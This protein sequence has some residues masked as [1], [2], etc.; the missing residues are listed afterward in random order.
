MNRQKDRGDRA[1]REI[2]ALLTELLGQPIRR[3]LGAGRLDDTGDLDGLTG[4]T[5]QVA[6]WS[7]ALRA[8][9]EKPIAAEAQRLRARDPYA[10]TF[11]KLRGGL[12]R[13]VQTLEQ[14]AEVVR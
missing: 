11:V 8:V 4:W 13:S 7:D 12:W 1:E 5:L 14:F 9:R 10:A 6:D 3:K 2:A